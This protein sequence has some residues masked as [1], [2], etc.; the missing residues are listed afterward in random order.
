MPKIE[1]NVNRW[2]CKYCTY[3]NFPASTKCALCKSKREDTHLNQNV[4]D[5]IEEEQVTGKNNHSETSEQV[6]LLQGRWAC[7]SC[8]YLNWENSLKCVMCMNGRPNDFVPPSKTID[9]L[10]KNQAENHNDLTVNNN[11]KNK[12]ISKNKQKWT[13]PQCTLEN[14]NGSKKCS[15]C[16]KAKPGESAILKTKNSQ[17]VLNLKKSG[18]QRARPATGK[19]IAAAIQ[20][21]TSEDEEQ[22]IYGLSATSISAVSQ[23]KNNLQESDWM[24]LSACIGVVEGE[25]SSVKMF[26][27]SGGSAARKLTADEVLVLNRP[28]VFEIDDTLVHLAIRY[29][30]DDLLAMMLP[31]EVSRKTFKRMPCH[32]SPDLAASVRKQAAQ[33]LRQRKGDWPCYFYTDLVTFTLPGGKKLC[34]FIIFTITTY[35]ILCCFLHSD[36]NQI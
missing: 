14:W 22:L 16:S 32:V 12:S 20:P 25:P 13:C 24:W 30:R 8:T 19:S 1:Q 17:N 23:I 3:D 2:S 4:N 35:Y 5:R 11:E 28:G 18:R 31:H 7:L 10:A 33:G 34:F 21:I 36:R 27:S 9:S 6:D 26:L 15:L 29:H